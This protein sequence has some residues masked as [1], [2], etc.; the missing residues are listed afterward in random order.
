MIRSYGKDLPELFR[1][2][3]LGMMDFIFGEQ[4]KTCETDQADEVEIES[5]DAEAL[6][7]DWL[8]ELNYL[9]NTNYRAYIDYEFEQFSERRIRAK[10]KSCKALAEEDIKAVTFHNLKIEK[11]DDLWQVTIV[12][13]I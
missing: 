1:N 6:L 11:I 2:S 10:V 8:S 12:Y 13:D 4:L 5:E 7:V 3:A 9:V